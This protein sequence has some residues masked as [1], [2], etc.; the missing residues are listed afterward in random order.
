MSTKQ[1][2]R[3][4]N[5]TKHPEED[6]QYRLAFY[7]TAVAMAYGDPDGGMAEVNDPFCA[8]LG[9]TREELLGMTFPEFTHPEDLDS[10]IELYT[11]LTRGGIPSYCLEK[12]YIRKDGGYVHVIL[13]V[14][15]IHNE[16]GRIQ[17]FFAVINDVTELRHTQADLRE[18]E[19]KFSKAFFGSPAF[20]II[21]EL[22]TGTIIEVNQAYADMIG[23]AREEILGRS[24]SD[25]GVLQPENRAE[26][27]EQLTRTGR[28]HDREM[29]GADRKGRPVWTIVSSQ[30]MEYNGRQ[31]LISSGVDITSRKAQEVEAKRADRARSD[32]LSNM[33]HEFRTPLNGI[34]G[35]VTLARLKS[36]DPRVKEYL[37]HA[38][39]SADQLLDLVN[40]ALDL[41]EIRTGHIAVNKRSFS[42]P[43]LVQSCVEPYKALALDKGLEVSS[44]IGTDAAQDLSGDDGHLRHVLMNLLDNAVKFT[45]KGRVEVLVEALSSANRSPVRMR[46]Q[47]RDTGIGIPEQKLESIF[48]SFPFAGSSHHTK[49]GGAGMGLAIAKQLI[50]LMNGTLEV[51]SLEGQGS[52]FR[53]VLEFEAAAAAVD[54]KHGDGDES[55]LSGRSLKILVAEDNTMNQLFIMDLLESA[56]HIPVLANNGLEALEKL[57]DDHFD[58]VIMDIR[59]PKMDGEETAR[60]IRNDP[61]QGTDPTIPIIALSAFSQQNEIDSALHCG[62]NAYL[63]KPLDIDKL[64][65]ILADL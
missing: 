31:C 20:L 59:M 53:F 26:Y 8:L 39:R 22:K 23:Y 16:D 55:K 19:E 3:R 62:C 10:D 56:G 58:L 40:N 65:A 17:S 50:E 7:Q 35:M 6:N 38:S 54:D 37:D 25:L 21:T 36:G 14:T 5:Q 28:V 41:S 15:A 33:S 43:G 63:T 30:L 60:K 46:F 2:N 48:E 11:K 27:I 1:P 51:E 34:M 49:F 42:L 47:I 52:T 18:N 45:E 13:N 64:N 24:A 4:R 12:R 57:V 9:Y 44:T 29:R 32:F 61:P